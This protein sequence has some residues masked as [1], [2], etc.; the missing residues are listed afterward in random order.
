MALYKEQNSPAPFVASK[1]F[2]VNVVYPVFTVGDG[3]FSF[4]AYGTAI[5][6]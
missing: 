4:V 3:V 6:P 2:S 5:I 1:E